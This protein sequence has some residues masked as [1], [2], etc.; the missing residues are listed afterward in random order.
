MADLGAIEFLWDGTANV[1][2]SDHWGREGVFP[3]W[4]GEVNGTDTYTNDP[5][6]LGSAAGVFP[7]GGPA[8]STTVAWLYIGAEIVADYVIPATVTSCGRVTNEVLG[9]IVTVTCNCTGNLADEIG[10]SVTGG[11]RVKAGLTIDG[12]ISAGG[13]IALERGVS[14]LGEQPVTS[15]GIQ[16]GSAGVVLGDNCTVAY[17]IGGSG[18]DAPLTV[19]TG[20]SVAA[21]GGDVAATSLVTPAKAEPTPLVI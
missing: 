15:Y 2:A 13:L 10:S 6:A 11:Y 7:T 3:K 1:W 5:V 9:K 4:P 16:C 19:G 18:G 21:T 14:V 12:F 17:G 8:A 20:C